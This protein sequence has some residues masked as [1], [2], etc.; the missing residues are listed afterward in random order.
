MPGN[1]F[2]STRRSRI[3]PTDLGEKGCLGRDDPHAYIGC[4]LPSGKTRHILLRNRDEKRP[5]PD[6]VAR[7]IDHLIL[8]GHHRFHGRESDPAADEGMDAIGADDHL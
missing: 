2:D 1:F 8:E 6:V 7:G 3:D 5:P 4:L